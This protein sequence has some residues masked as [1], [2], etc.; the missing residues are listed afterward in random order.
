MKGAD[1]L[2]DTKGVVILIGLAVAGYLVYRLVKV[3]PKLPTPGNSTNADGTAQTAY[4][5]TGPVGYV[6]AATNAASGG[7]LS[8]FGDWLG[9][10]AYDLTNTDPM[11]QLTSANAATTGS[12]DAAVT[13]Y[14]NPIDYGSPG[15]F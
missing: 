9:G 5:N 11:A 15:G 8:Q 6:A 10:A 14:N 3:A 4:Q 7:Y 2:N 13:L 12:N 1:F